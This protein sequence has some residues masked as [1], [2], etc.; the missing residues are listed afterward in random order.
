MQYQGFCGKYGFL[1]MLPIGYGLPVVL[2]A[3]IN[4][5]MGLDFFA[6]AGHSV[7]LGCYAFAAAAGVHGIANVALG[8]KGVGL[9]KG[10]RLCKQFQAAAYAVTVATGLY[11]NAGENPDQKTEQKTVSMDSK[12]PS[13]QIMDARIFVLG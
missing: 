1:T 12:M 5:V 9:T 10:S 11:L 3:P 13:K 8:I 4:Y 7:T 2:N 6:Q